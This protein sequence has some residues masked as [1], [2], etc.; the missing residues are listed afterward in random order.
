MS[1]YKLTPE[2]QQDLVC[3]L[4]LIAGTFRPLEIIAVYTAR[5]LEAFFRRRI[6]D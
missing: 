1:T 5:D 2:A 4:L 3:V 6:V